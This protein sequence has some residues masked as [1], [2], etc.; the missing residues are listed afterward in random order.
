M[1]IGINARFLN[2]PFTGIGQY[3]RYLFA[4]L[5]ELNPDI[6]FLMVATEEPFDD[7]DK[8]IPLAAKLPRNIKIVVVPEK[9]NWRFVP[10]GFRKAYW[11]QNQ[12]IKYFKEQKVDLIHIPYPANPVRKLK[13]PVVTT[14]HDVI[15]W[16]LD[17]YRKNLRTKIYQNK[18]KKN[19]KK[20][21]L[22][23]TVS[24]ASKKEICE[25]CEIDKNKIRTVY[26]G[27]NPQLS[28]DLSL[29]IKA[30]ILEKLGLDI[31]RPFFLYVGGFDERKNVRL[32]IESYLSSVAADYGYDLVI[33]GGKS[34]ESPLYN[35]YSNLTKVIAERSVD[36]KKG[37]IKMTGFVNE[38]E[39]AALYQTAFSF[40][41]L[42]KSEGFNLPLV[43]AISCGCPVICT[44]LAVHKELLENAVMFCRS[45][46]NTKED[47]AKIIERLI[48]DKDYYNLQKNRIKNIKQ[49]FTWL[50]AAQ[51]TVKIYR[52]L[53]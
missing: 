20:S 4:F 44:D 42:S 28:K 53:L 15:P 37:M 25:V 52:E 26:N 6:E 36:D 49:K 7:L 33:V 41:N 40:I 46:E 45:L 3:T 43:E 27:V 12:I 21:N 34:L 31:R 29:K 50:K 17:E 8:K 13:I 30:E 18:A 24:N 5:A 39:L 9:F 22:I 11:E 1:K 10:A 35:S 2:K 47:A 16:T 14:V 51:E 23:I 48:T 32:M 19:L 38:E